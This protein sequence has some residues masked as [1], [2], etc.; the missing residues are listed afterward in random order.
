MFANFAKDITDDG[1]MQTFMN[2]ALLLRSER[3]M[4]KIIDGSV[5]RNAVEANVFFGANRNI[6]YA[7]LT[8]RA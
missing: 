7:V 1:Y 3:D 4:W 2:W 6:V 5:D 8:R